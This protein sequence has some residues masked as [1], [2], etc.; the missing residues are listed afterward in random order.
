MIRVVDAAAAPVTLRLREGYRIA[1]HHFSTASMVLL[2][3][4]T[5][6]DRT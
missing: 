2:R 6:R 3:I 1:G 4:T 5:S